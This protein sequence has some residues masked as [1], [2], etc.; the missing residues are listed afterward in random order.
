MTHTNNSIETI[1]EEPA[2]RL[3]VDIG[4]LKV[5]IEKAATEDSFVNEFLYTI[6]EYTR[7]IIQ[8][9][10]YIREHCRQNH[11]PLY[12]PVDIADA[13]ISGDIKIQTLLP[14]T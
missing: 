13:L 14:I 8:Q 2:L 4:K 3:N 6:P 12:R 7:E 10:L 5:A 11:L 9:F 1:T